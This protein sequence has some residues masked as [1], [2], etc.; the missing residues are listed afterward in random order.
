LT[1]FNKKYAGRF[2]CRIQE[3]SKKIFCVI[4]Q[5]KKFTPAAAENFFSGPY[6]DES[7]TTREEKS[8]V[9]NYAQPT[10][11]GQKRKI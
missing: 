2:C 7:E 8:R 11:I 4:S 3:I 10:F 5:F 9:L 6:R 1:G